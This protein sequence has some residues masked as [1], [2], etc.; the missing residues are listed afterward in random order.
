MPAS[1]GLLG[2]IQRANDDASRRFGP[3]TAEVEAFINAVG[4]LTPWQWRQVLASRRL[5]ASVTKEGAGE[6][7][8][9]I[10]DAIRGS[11][12]RMSEPM[13]KAGEILFDTLMR[14]SEEKQ[15]AAWQAM[16]A[17]VSRNSLPALKFAAHYAP[18]ATLIPLSGS[19]VLEPPT[20]RFMVELEGL[21][22]E[23][24]EA[25]GR[26]W[27]LEPEVSRALLQAVA[28][29]REARSEESVAMA[30][31]TLIPAQVTGDSGWAAVRTAV[32]GGRV[33]GSLSD[34]SPDQV[35][36]LWAPIE[37]VVPFAS[38]TVENHA[39]AEAVKAAVS[40]AIRTIRAPRKRPA[41]AAPP[42]AAAPYGSNS[43][44]VAVF[45]KTV[46][47]LTA[48]QWLRVLD[49][50]ALVASVTRDSTDEPAGVVRS[51]LASIEGTRELDTF[52][53]CRAFAAVERAG[54]AIES[55]GR[56]TG[57]QAKEM[58]RPFAHSIPLDS[59]NGGGFAHKLASLS[60]HDWERVAAEAPAA[61]EEAVAPLVNA[62]T[63]LVDFFGGRS[64][65]EAVAAWHAVSALVRRHHLTPIKFAASYAPFA[66]AIPVTNPRS[67]GALVSRYVT[68]VGRLGSSQCAA[69]A[70]EWT[71]DDELSS[72][73]SRAV[74]DG[75][76][77]TGEEAAALA[78]VVTVPMRVSGAHGWAAVK[79]A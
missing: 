7:S 53:R 63:A 21:T 78:A 19:D 9:A 76:T 43:S 15:V 74:A 18:F 47:E 50:R 2:R 4:L 3:N 56:M 52:T 48:I 23:Q 8:R 25:L 42:K 60:K 34:L 36:E 75:A 38:L 12:S 13:S 71:L 16:S 61:N 73:L 5:V 11:D 68:A 62:G 33:L 58:Y 39:A 37:Q 1:H 35:A 72:A 27:R 57:E 46:G 67:L 55:E 20:R 69:L 6:S 65:D 64:D 32:H 40:S 41:A 54:Y 45:I 77:R 22:A 31:L 51:I 26:R 49:R 59:V 24:C 30:A 44:E 10:Q 70:K 29:H 28:N 66:S 14:K 17:L 79:T